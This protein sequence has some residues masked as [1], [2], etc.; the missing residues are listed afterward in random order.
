MGN[1]CVVTKKTCRQ[2]GTPSAFH[3]NKGIALGT[4]SLDINSVVNVHIQKEPGGYCTL[5]AYKTM[6]GICIALLAFS[7]P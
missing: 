7:E 5:E 4:G 6:P 1:Q 2:Q 3:W